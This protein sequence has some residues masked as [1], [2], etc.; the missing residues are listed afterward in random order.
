MCVSWIVT[1]EH[2]DVALRED[3]EPTYKR[4][5]HHNTAETSG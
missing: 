4:W 3:V 5:L 1:H 2:V